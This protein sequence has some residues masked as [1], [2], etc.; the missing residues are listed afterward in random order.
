MEA[1]TSKGHKIL[2]VRKAKGDQLWHLVY[3][4][5]GRLTYD[6]VDRKT[7]LRISKLV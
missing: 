3:K 6:R 1:L 4:Y 7:A 5:N 2:E